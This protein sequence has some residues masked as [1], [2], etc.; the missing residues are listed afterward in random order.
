MVRLVKHRALSRQQLGVTA[1]AQS[2]SVAG[3]LLFA[4][5]T[6]PSPQK[7]GEGFSKHLLY[8]LNAVPLL[9]PTDSFSAAPSPSSFWG[10]QASV[11]KQLEFVRCSFFIHST[12]F[13]WVHGNC[14]PFLLDRSW[15]K[16]LYHQ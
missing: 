10:G 9:M 1:V 14:M 6:A 3:E 12:S 8:S 2:P 15:L 11:A 4:A 5:G 13:L 16:I 7:K